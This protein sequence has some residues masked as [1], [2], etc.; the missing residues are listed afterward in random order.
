M[1]GAIYTIIFELLS[2][3]AAVPDPP[4]MKLL[5][6]VAVHVLGVHIYILT[7]VRQRKTFIKVTHV[8]CTLSIL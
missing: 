4:M 7:Q 6:H 1:A 2:S 3:N 8:S 5:L